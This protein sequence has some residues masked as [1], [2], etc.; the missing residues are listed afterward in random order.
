MATI[1]DN[2]PKS[3]SLTGL[4]QAGL[5]G[6][7]VA[8]VINIVLYFV[9]GTMGA[10]YMVTAGP[11]TPLAELPF[12]MVAVMSIVPGLAAALLWF[13]LQR[14]GTNGTR[15]FYAI[16]VIVFLFFL[17]P[18]TGD[19]QTITKVFLFIMHVVVA[20]SVIYFLN[21]AAR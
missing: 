6:G 17:A 18:F 20:A 7:V 5:I 16:A 10:D 3:A 14:F 2:N 11:G 21:R 13:G 19:F 9:G 15:I 8:A 12:F 1:Y 4:L